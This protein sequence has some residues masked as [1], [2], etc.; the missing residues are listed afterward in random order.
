MNMSLANLDDLIV[1]FPQ[2]QDAIQRLAELVDD[3]SETAG[4]IFSLQRLYDLASP[5]TTIV[6]AHLLN[7]LVAT[8]VMK[9]IVRVESPILG[10]IEDFSSMTEVPETILDWRQDLT[11]EVKPENIRVLY[12][13]VAS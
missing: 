10:V 8:G 3:N 9:K 13:V 5:S 1:K 4:K 12:Q 2:D 11:I 7:H 6:F